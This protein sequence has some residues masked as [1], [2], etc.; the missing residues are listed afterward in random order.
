MQRVAAQFRTQFLLCNACQFD[1]DRLLNAVGAF[2]HFTKL[3]NKSARSAGSN[4]PKSSS[5]PASFSA[6]VWH[7]A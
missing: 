2:S 6:T 3:F 1:G 5:T 4:N 7:F